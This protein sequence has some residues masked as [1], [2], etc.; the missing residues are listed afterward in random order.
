VS[1]EGEE[2]GVRWRVANDL[3]AKREGERRGSQSVCARVMRLP[4]Q[5]VEQG[6]QRTYESAKMTVG[7]WLRRNTLDQLLYLTSP[8]AEDC[9]STHVSTSTLSLPSPAMHHR[10]APVVHRVSIL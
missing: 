5:G 10:P 9:P 4:L 1:E 3:R 7:R 8:V 2:V 6:R